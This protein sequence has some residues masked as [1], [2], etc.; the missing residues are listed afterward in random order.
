M[1]TMN[2]PSNFE[3]PRASKI[4]EALSLEPGKLTGIELALRD[5]LVWVPGEGVG[6]A[7][8]RSKGEFRIH[9]RY[10]GLFACLTPRQIK[11]YLRERL[12]GGGAPDP[13]L[14]AT[15]M[16]RALFYSMWRLHRDEYGL[17]RTLAYAAEAAV[18]ADP[19]TDPGKVNGNA[20][21]AFHLQLQTLARTSSV[22]DSEAVQSCWPR[23][24]AERALL[25]RLMILSR[26]ENET[27]RTRKGQT[28]PDWVHEQFGERL[29]GVSIAEQLSSFQDIALARLQSGDR[30]A[31]QT[32]ASYADN[33]L[34]EHAKAL[35]AKAAPSLSNLGAM[36]NDMP[37][38]ETECDRL[39]RAAARLA[40][41]GTRIP[42]YYAE[43]L[44]DALS[45]TG[46]SER[47]VPAR[48]ESV[49]SAKAQAR[50]I[51]SAVA[52]AAME[53]KDRFYRDLLLDRLDMA[54]GEDNNIRMGR[55]WRLVSQ[56][57]HARLLAEGT[58]ESASRLNDALDAAIGK[59]GLT[60]TIK[61]PLQGMVWALQSRFGAPAWSMAVQIANDLVGEGSQDSREEKCGLRMNAA[62]TS[63]PA[64]L[65]ATSERARL[66]AIWSQSG[67]L[68][69]QR[70]GKRA[71]DRIAL[72]FLASVVHGGEPQWQA[73]A[74][75][76]WIN[77]SGKEGQPDPDA[78][79]KLIN[80][81][82][83]RLLGEIQQL[84]ADPASAEKLAE[85]VFAPE[86]WPSLD[87]AE[88]LAEM[89]KWNE[90]KFAWAEGQSFEQAVA[91]LLDAA[92]GPTGVSA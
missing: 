41:P 71:Q 9:E 55:L 23:K 47:L 67:N 62:L 31:L 6:G 53:P 51:L 20:L 7:P 57:S 46:R 72:A 42:F 22:L 30:S 19:E 69:S 2:N 90:A 26:D 40:R 18:K 81:D 83:T 49:D 60:L 92:G 52:D 66:A 87:T 61:E 80:P 48:Y 33:F 73:R 50:G 76:S 29:R 10:R 88:S 8:E 38:A 21:E 3:K 58:R 4:D 64:L 5:L 25:L 12:V 27:G 74:D 70:I 56:P 78:W 68:L 84:P 17:F 85:M 79:L 11:S 37:G 24:S 77:I 45:D 34:A 32:V 44:L 54:E 89:L 65:S 16:L 35:D 1:A 15:A 82:Q 39:F 63:D 86:Y 36:I 13:D 91:A 43:F 75:Q 28:F 14:P 59:G